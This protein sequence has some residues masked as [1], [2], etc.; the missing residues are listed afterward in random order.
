MIIYQY[1]PTNSGYIWTASGERAFVSG[2]VK[3][4]PG[5]DQIGSSFVFVFIFGE[6]DCIL[7]LQRFLI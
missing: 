1:G 2:L 6:I 7:I 5:L 3:I 4:P